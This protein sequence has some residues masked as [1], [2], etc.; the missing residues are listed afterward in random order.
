MS[1]IAGY[2]KA[3]TGAVAPGAVLIGAAVTEGSQGGTTITQAEW[4][5][6][7]VAVIVTGG[8]VWAAPANK[9]TN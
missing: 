6:A 8:A 2:W 4:V 9:P 7:V 3:L 5:T 1:K